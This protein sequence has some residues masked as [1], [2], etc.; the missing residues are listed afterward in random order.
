MSQQP[1][2][3]EREGT[4]GQGLAAAEGV[5]QE[6]ELIDSTE[7]IEDDSP[8]PPP[9]KRVA[10][11]SA[12]SMPAITDQDRE[13]V[14]RVF[15]QV[16][17]VDFRAPPPPPPRK[18]LAGPDR[19]I[20][21]LRQNVHELERDLARVGY[22][23][24]S[25]QQQYRAADELVRA[26][27]ADR[28]AAIARYNQIKDLSGQTAMRD[29]AEID[30]LKHQ[31]A[32]LEA[33]RVALE[34]ELS[35]TQALAAERQQRS[36]QEKAAMMA[37]YRAN[38]EAAQQAFNQLRD[39]S[40]QA[41]LNLETALKQRE[42]ELDTRSRAL[43]EATVS[44]ADR[45]SELEVARA[46]LAEQEAALVAA[47]AEQA[48][49]ETALREGSRSISTLTDE[50]T[51]LREQHETVIHELRDSLKAKEELVKVTRGEVQS[52]RAEFDQLAEQY[53]ARRVELEKASAEI[54]RL[55]QEVEDAKRD[56]GASVETASA[57]AADL[58]EA[59]EEARLA[60]ADVQNLGQELEALRNSA[61]NPT[62]NRG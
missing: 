15:L 11:D 52:A 44:L 26:K 49:Q 29:R 37:D 3:P 40:G 42:E 36:E 48:R 57:R 16:R 22:V 55:H 10:F 61:I 35:S 58:E 4:G 30:A 41:I 9:P 45:T 25:L 2:A 34:A 24:G 31:V 38:M 32:K 7:A 56:L 43:D 21:A 54:A 23:W 47:R 19:K 62:D 20:A 12:P 5:D 33:R 46:T 14:Q 13:F 28:E 8:P 17:D 50:L 6:P 59:R 51:R 39:T 1:S 60:R 27:E 53:E 18:D